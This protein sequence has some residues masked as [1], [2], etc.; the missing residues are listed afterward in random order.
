MEL[1]E[2][3]GKDYCRKVFDYIA[4]EDSPRPVTYQTELLRRVGFSEVE[5]LHKNGPFAALGAVKR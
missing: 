1:T 4:Y 3:G 2:I 5:I